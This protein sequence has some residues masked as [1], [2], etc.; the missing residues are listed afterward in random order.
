MAPLFFFATRVRRGAQQ[1]KNGNRYWR[2]VCPSDQM[3][4]PPND[5]ISFG[6]AVGRLAH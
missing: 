5:A 1:T 3:M 2:A 6:S 4:V